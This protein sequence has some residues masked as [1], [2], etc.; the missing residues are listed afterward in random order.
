MNIQSLF[1]DLV[2]DS[3]NSTTVSDDFIC[4]YGL[5]YQLY[6][7]LELLAESHPMYVRYDLSDKFFMDE[8]DL[9]KFYYNLRYVTIWHEDKDKLISF[10]VPGTNFPQVIGKVLIENDWCEPSSIQHWI[11]N[12]KLYKLSKEGYAVYQSSFKW[13]N[14]LSLV[15]KLKISVCE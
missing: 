8:D 2:H 4:Y 5:R 9:T 13:W 15:E 1:L 11:P 3:I 7:A 14:S 6:I 12:I 10:F